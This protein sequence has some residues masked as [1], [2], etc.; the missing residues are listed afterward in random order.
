[1]VKD[2]VPE[3]AENAEDLDNRVRQCWDELHE[4]P[5]FFEKLATS[6]SRR[7]DEVVDANG[8]Y[9]HY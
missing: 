4:E 5:Q 1:M 9:I 6:M 3:A 8:S 2:W 7:L